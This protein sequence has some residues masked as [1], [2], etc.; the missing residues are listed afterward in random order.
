[1]ITLKKFQNKHLKV[2]KNY[3]KINPSVLCE[4]SCGVI[5]MWEEYYNFYFTIY[6]E[7][8]IVASKKNDVF[9]FFPPVGKNENGAYEQIE[10]F[11]VNKV[12][13][14]EFIGV[15]ENSKAFLCQKYSIEKERFDRDF[16][17]YIYSY[18]EIETFVGKKFSGQRNHINAFKK[19]Y[20]NYKYKTI[21]KSDEKRL[22]EFLGEYKL[23]HSDMGDIEKKEYLNTLNLLKNL[24]IADFFGAYLEVDGKIVAMTIGEYLKN[25]LI[26]HV[27]KA[28]REYRGAYPTMFN[29][30][31]RHSK[32]DGV[33]YINREDDSGDLGLRSSK[34]QYQP[35]MIANKYR[36]TVKNP[37]QIKRAPRLKGER[38]L[39]SK[40]TKSDQKD[41]AKLYRQVKNN[42]YW[43]YD[44][45]KHIKNPTDDYF[46]KMAIK[47]FKRRENLCL[48]IRNR[49]SGAFMGEIVLYNF[50]YDDTVEVGYRLFKKYQKKGYATESLLLAK[51]YIKNTLKKVAIAKCYKQNKNSINLLNKSDFEKISEDKKYFYYKEKLS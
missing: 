25:S 36:L 18:E 28:S 30:F 26:I 35:I 8:L 44:Y 19:L 38:V 47:D 29:E 41:Y 45:K 23:G 42:R 13:P 15:D 16:S 32:K 21:L 11:C 6:D 49:K 46:V 39:L 17:D 40:I 20:P 7:T 24:K 33:I 50:G 34:L 4:L 48:A 27:E 9:R 31:V 22:V 5:Y 43:G 51:N 12:I 1:M 2:I 10:K 37:M 3:T 14:L